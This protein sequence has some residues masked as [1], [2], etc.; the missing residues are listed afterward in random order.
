MVNPPIP[1]I[2]INYKWHV[3]HPK[4]WVTAFRLIDGWATPVLLQEKR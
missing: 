1:S 3:A 4:S 2:V